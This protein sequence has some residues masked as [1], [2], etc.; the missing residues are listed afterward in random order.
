MFVQINLLIYYTDD[1][2]INLP[3]IINS[4]FKK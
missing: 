4:Y 1:L 2:L 3:K